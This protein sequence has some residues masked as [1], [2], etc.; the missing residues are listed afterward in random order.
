[1]SSPSSCA[2]SE[3]S[4]AAAAELAGKMADVNVVDSC[5]GDTSLPADAA[6]ADTDE[7]ESCHEDVNTV[8]HDSTA[9][10]Q[11][12]VEAQPDAQDTV[13]PSPDEDTESGTHLYA[14][15]CCEFGAVF[16]TMTCNQISCSKM[17]VGDR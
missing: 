12:S 10:V 9:A 3:S 1:L 11:H 15:L 7:A 2:E 13:I 5:H 4:A 14:H 16:K 6:L 17:C 8:Q